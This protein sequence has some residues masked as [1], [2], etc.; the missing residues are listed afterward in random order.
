MDT[1]DELR[2]WMADYSRQLKMV[3]MP[4]ALPQSTQKEFDKFMVLPPRL[5]S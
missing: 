2:R 4:G 1:V 5:C 3:K